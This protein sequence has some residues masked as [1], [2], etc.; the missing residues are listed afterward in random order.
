MPDHSDKHMALEN[1]V[2]TEAER[3]RAHMGDMAQTMVHSSTDM[4]RDD[5]HIRVQTPT[6]G[7]ARDLDSRLQIP[8]YMDVHALGLESAVVEIGCIAASLETDRAFRVYLHRDV[9]NKHGVPVIEHVHRGLAHGTP[10][11][12]HTCQSAIQLAKT[13]NPRGSN[14][15][16]LRTFLSPRIGHG[17]G[18]ESVSGC[19][20][21]VSGCED[22]RVERQ[23]CMYRQVG[24]RVNGSCRL[25]LEVN[26]F[27]QNADD[28]GSCCLDLLE[29]ESG[30]VRFEGGKTRHD[31]ETRRCSHGY[32]GRGRRGSRALGLDH[33]LEHDHGHDSRL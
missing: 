17:G 28:R 14:S 11:T 21:Q 16:S 2:E 4:Q 27:A 6:F 5:L 24:D 7:F 3:R 33:A 10:G 23:E 12:C 30:C 15:G 19:G 18:C 29:V 20:N 1:D 32:G 22:D 13:H 8:E 26:G 9:E 25:Y 31:P